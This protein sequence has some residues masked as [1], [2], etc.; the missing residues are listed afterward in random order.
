MDYH[1]QVPG[2]D[3][4]DERGDPQYNQEQ[5]QADQG[6][7]EFDTPT[8]DPSQL[9][10]NR[11][12]FEQPEAAQFAFPIIQH[13]H[14]DS[15]APAA[16]PQLQQRDSN[17]H[18]LSVNTAPPFASR[19]TISPRREYHSETSANSQTRF[20]NKFLGS[21]FSNGSAVLNPYSGQLVR[22][23]SCLFSLLY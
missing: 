18:Q 22:S 2:P 21:T 8:L 14:G 3:P 10:M 7:P 12:M 23:I 20:N 15:W 11:N 9:S 19:Q 13:V 17:V 16:N 5:T 4:A 6:F 1:M